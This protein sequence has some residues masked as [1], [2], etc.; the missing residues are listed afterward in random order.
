MGGFKPS[1]A[2]IAG[3]T[4][5][6]SIQTDLHQ[7][8]GSVD[9]TGSLKLNGSSVT[10]GGGA[11]ANYTNSGNNRVITSV[12]SDTINGEANLTFDGTKMGVGSNHTPTAVLHVS[13]STTTLPLFRVDQHDQAGSKPIVFVTGSGLVG[14]GTDAPR[15]DSAD[16]NRVH[17]LGESGTDQAQNP[18]D[19]T[20]LMLENNSHAAVQFMTPN[21]SAGI[22]AWGSP[23]V[24][25][26]A[27]LYYGIS[28]NRYHFEGP[29]FGSANVMTI[30]AAGNSVNIGQSQAA[31]MQSSTAC[32][33]I[34]SSTGGTDIGGPVLFKIDH[35][36]QPGAQPIML[37]TGSGRVGIGVADPDTTLEVLSTTTQQ[38]LS[39]DESNAASF[40]VN[41]G[42][43][44]TVATTK[45][46]ILDPAGG[47]VF[48]ERAGN[49]LRVEM[50]TG[51]TFFQNEVSGGNIG[52]KLNA[53][54]TSGI[55]EV[56][57]VDGSGVGALLV[58]GTVGTYPGGDAAINFRDTANSINSPGSNR[59]TITAPTLEVTGSTVM[60]GAFGNT[61]V[62]TLNVASASVDV[63]T[64]NTI[65]D[66][67]SLANNKLYAFGI[68]DG[69]F[70]GQ[71][72]NI[73]FKVT[74][75]GAPGNT[76]GVELTGSN[77]ASPFPG[78]STGVLSLS[79][80]DAGG[81]GGFQQI[82]VATTQLL[83]DG[84]DWQ[85]LAATN[86]Q[87]GAR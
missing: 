71:Q 40:T 33:A 10:G 57:R 35:G 84:A 54:G 51:T 15:T 69:L 47:D 79:G 19:N 34:S 52:F 66:A 39:Y 31:H 41:S 5:V 70:T 50:S 56:F 16:T 25:R 14:I 78:A 60:S 64:G 48:F 58:S 13:S 42:G 82:P 81:G 18:V 4:T 22:I 68:R 73:V 38:K 80:S 26:Q 61:A 86:I 53:A 9:I 49:R 20:V 27:N 77:I 44:L 67:T 83:W 74:F 37:V 63:T 55:P 87:Y 21:N 75:G 12:D 6:G 36:D 30:H 45:D 29:G 23:S 65:I 11:V 28:G 3:A 46:I 8:T 32:L 76:N 17:I 1:R 59:L 43:D 62:Q 7:F 24:P 72:K 85:V 2:D